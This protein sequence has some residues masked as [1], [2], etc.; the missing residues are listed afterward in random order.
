MGLWNKQQQKNRVEDRLKNVQ[1]K[2]CQYLWK[3]NILERS[4][5]AVEGGNE[6]RLA[7]KMVCLLGI[8]E[9]LPGIRWNC[10]LQN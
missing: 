1:E 5:S 7:F 10:P 3:W 8:W 4:R 6:A 9:D 2:V